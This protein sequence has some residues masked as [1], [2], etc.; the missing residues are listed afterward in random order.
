M[1]RASE[2]TA[3]LRLISLMRGRLEI[4]RL[5]LTEPSL[6]LVHAEDGRWN[7]EALLERT[8]HI[9]L[10]PTAKPKSEARPGFPY[11]QATSARINFKNGPEKKPYALTNADFSL[12][13]DS[14]NSWGVRLKAQPFRSD[15]NLNDM[16][17][18][19][20]TGTWQR[21]NTLHET[22]MRFMVEWNR[23]QL[24]QLTKFFTGNDQGWRGGVVVDATVSGTPTKLQITS[25]GSIQDFRG[26]QL[27]RS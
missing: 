1:L 21:A 22:P 20:V 18:L 15:L 27:T 10:A 23:A 19:Q 14:E 13:Q 11:I 25:D 4:S 17:T 6:N 8:A 16:G 12:W 9:P 24:G 3:N 7:L 2:V 5:D 26:V